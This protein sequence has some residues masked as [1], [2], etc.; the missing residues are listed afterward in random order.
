MEKLRIIAND[1]G[2]R[3]YKFTIAIPP[4]ESN[5][6]VIFVH[7]LATHADHIDRIEKELAPKRK[8]FIRRLNPFK[9]RAV[10]LTQ[11]TYVHGEYPSLSDTATITW[12]TQKNKLVT[13]PNP[14]ELKIA[15]S[16]LATYAKQAKR[17]L[18]EVILTLSKPILR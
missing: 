8:S 16:A 1:S 18:T 3:K 9:K 4:E 14:R 11:W 2:A 5:H 10:D 7:G 15:R 17:K 13:T 6:D 12:T